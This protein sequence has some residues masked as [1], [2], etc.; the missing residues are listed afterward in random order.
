ME[1]MTPEYAAIIFMVILI[2][3]FFIFT[4]YS[5]NKLPL[6]KRTVKRRKEKLQRLETLFLG[7]KLFLDLTTED[8]KLVDE[9]FMPV[10][11]EDTYA[12]P[13]IR[14]LSSILPK[15][16]LPL[17]VTKIWTSGRDYGLQYSD[18]TEE[19]FDFEILYCGDLHIIAKSPTL[20]EIYLPKRKY[21]EF[22]EDKKIKIKF[23]SSFDCYGYRTIIPEIV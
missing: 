19:A 15:K 10:D 16:F 4:A 17:V 5:K 3:G 22:G 9:N 14:Q 13:G 8:L 21:S 7:K 23:N 20:G 12:D 1:T 6:P 18:L 11:L 2:L